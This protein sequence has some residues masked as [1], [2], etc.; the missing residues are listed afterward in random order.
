MCLSRSAQPK[1]V[2]SSWTRRCSEIAVQL[3]NHTLA[4][5]SVSGSQGW[6][7]DPWRVWRLQTRK[8]NISLEKGQGTARDTC[9][10][11]EQLA[12]VR[13]ARLDARR[14]AP[15]GTS[16]LAA[17]HRNTTWRAVEFVR[18]MCQV[19]AGFAYAKPSS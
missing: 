13:R 18:A 9:G 2:K 16:S 11:E 14:N 5:S 8:E 6:K 15:V 19:R 10:V 17:R 7:P 12:H 4:L 1:A 3:Q